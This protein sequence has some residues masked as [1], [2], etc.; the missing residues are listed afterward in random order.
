MRGRGR[1]RISF[2]VLGCPENHFSCGGFAIER[3]TLYV[4]VNMNIFDIGYTLSI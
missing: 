4:Y 1:G 2:L 3:L